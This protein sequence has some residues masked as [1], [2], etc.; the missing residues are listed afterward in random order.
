[1][2]FYTAIQIENYIVLSSSLECIPK[3]L[4][5][6]HIIPYHHFTHYETWNF[7]Q[8]TSKTLQWKC[9][10]WK[11]FY[12]WM[13]LKLNN[14]V[15]ISSVNVERSIN[16][17]ICN[18]CIP[19]VGEVKRLRKLYVSNSQFS[20]RYLFSRLVCVVS[21]SLSS[22]IALAESLRETDKKVLISNSHELSFRW[23]AG[24]KWNVNVS[25][26]SENNLPPA[27][28]AW[29]LRRF[30]FFLS[31]HVK[32]RKWIISVV[33]EMVKLMKFLDALRHLWQPSI[34]HTIILSSRAQH[35]SDIIMQNICNN[36][37]FCNL[38]LFSKWSQF[39][40]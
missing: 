39:F 17:F 19:C 22:F 24:V 9:D 14:D 27:L 35:V 4:W 1:M 21:S 31:W 32:E 5:T 26:R 30:L 28:E 16:I 15:T 8:N 11:V 6:L 34:E 36:W 2:L 7:Q 25:C 29:C 37:S 40:A 23:K 18:I 20:A 10:K 33:C 13:S 12:A 38:L 3:M